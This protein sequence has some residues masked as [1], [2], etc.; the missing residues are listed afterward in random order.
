MLDMNMS[1]RNSLPLI[2][3]SHCCQLWSVFRKAVCVWWGGRGEGGAQFPTNPTVPPSLGLALLFWKQSLLLQ[4]ESSTYCPAPWKGMAVPPG[5]LHMSVTWCFSERHRHL[6]MPVNLDTTLACG[7]LGSLHY[8]GLP[9]LICREDIISST[10]R[11]N[12]MAA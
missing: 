1:F 6:A 2:S 5:L 4:G 7:H 9:F 12:K 11:R 8:H 3:H 10:W